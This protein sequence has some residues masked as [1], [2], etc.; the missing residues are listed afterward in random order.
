[1]SIHSIFLLTS[2]GFLAGFIDR[3]FLHQGFIDRFFPG[4]IYRFFSKKNIINNHFYF[5]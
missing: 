1:M 4:F 3:F 5:N 2:L